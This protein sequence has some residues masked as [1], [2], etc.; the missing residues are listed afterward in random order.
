MKSVSKFSKVVLPSA[1]LAAISLFGLAA[2][3]N[4]VPFSGGNYLNSLESSHRL[5]G[6]AETL[7]TKLAGTPVLKPIVAANATLRLVRKIEAPGFAVAHKDPILTTNEQ[8]YAAIC[9]FNTTSDG[10]QAKM[11]VYDLPD[12]NGDTIDPGG[13]G[14]Q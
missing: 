7:C 13:S 11:W 14:Q 2:C 9:L 12:G 8:G 4:P 3:A 1:A 10:Q 6:R 5:D